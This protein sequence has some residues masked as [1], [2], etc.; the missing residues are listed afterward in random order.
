[1]R[2]CV[3]TQSYAPHDRRHASLVPVSKKGD[4]CQCDSWR[5]TALLDV[6]GELC[7][8]LIQNQLR[9]VVKNEVP[10]QQCGFRVGRRC[11]DAAFYALQ[12]IE[13]A[14]EHHCKLFLI[15]I[16]LCLVRG[17]GML[18]MRTWLQK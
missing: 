14:Y 2:A 4:L 11:P 18:L 15:F 13:K 17:C 9:S 6:V 5:G 1:M 16:N 8:R 7:G 10:E 3:W 12:V